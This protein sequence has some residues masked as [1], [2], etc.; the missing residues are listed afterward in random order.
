MNTKKLITTIAIALVVLITGCSKDDVQQ[1]IGE[2]PVVANV[3]PENGTINVPLSK[4]ISV[5]FSQEMKA[6]TFDSSSFTI[7]GSTLVAGTVSI[8]GKTATFIPT[9]PLTANTTYTGTI[10]T[11]VKNLLDQALEA[12]YVWTF[13]TGT[14]LNPM[15]LSTDPINKSIN[16]VLNKVVAANFNMSMNQ[17]T[18]NTNSFI[19]KQGATVVTGSISY[20][21]TTAYFKPSV[22][23]MANTLYT[24][25]ITTE[26]KNIQGTALSSNYVWTFTTGATTAPTVVSTDPLDNATA[27]LLNKS[28]SAT[29][30]IAIDPKTIN[31]KTFTVKNG[32]TA[33]VGIVSY[34]GTTATFDPSS[35]LLPGTIYTATISGAKNMAGVA[36]ANDYVW[37]F[38]TSSSL[39]GNTVNLGSAER[40]GIL[41]GVGVSN[42]AGFS[43]IRNMDVGIS[44]GVRSSV[45]GFPPAI[46]VEGAIYASDD[47]APPGIGAML[48]K[49]KQDLT[50]AYL[51]AEG[52]STPAPATVSGDQG[53]KT[54]APGIYKSTSTLL[55]QSG[56]L[57]LDAQGDANAVWIFQVAS[58]F[59][60]VGGAGGNVILS[61]GAQAKNIFWQVGRSATIGNYT[62]FKGNILALTS[63]TLNSHAT[64]QGRLLARNGS[65]VMTHT[66]II[67]KP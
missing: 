32:T 65:I 15:V 62:I 11:T 27:T 52:A 30:S 53:G 47:I 61:G 59:T 9:A 40:F 48:I 33:L 35:D 67:S 51:F 38:S 3:N 54:L 2:S 41:A 8:S 25:T 28:I 4:A 36:L 21:G 55:I 31:D 12:D 6:S 29:F 18:I 42:N 23:L 64:V 22:S 66:N 1:T 7:Q 20:I 24:A 26:A 49:A 14:T 13:S 34:S 16:V 50:N 63:I 10:K 60:T 37:N 43:E 58:D 17:S 5:D 45:T 19:V 39:V 56:D 44:P 57:T 46:I